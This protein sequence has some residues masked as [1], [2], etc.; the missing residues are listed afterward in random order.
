MKQKSLV[1]EQKAS[2]S[3]PPYDPVH[4]IMCNRNGIVIYY[5]AIDNYSGRIVIN[6]NGTLRFGKDR[7]KSQH[8]KVKFTNKDK[9]WW[10]V[11]EAL[12]TQEFMKL[13]ETLR[14][15]RLHEIDLEIIIMINKK[16]NEKHQG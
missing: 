6:D 5:D 3:R 16:A 13:P 12:Y 15:R 10:K 4:A 8:P 7:Y 11:I 9:R 2:T 14:I 1:T